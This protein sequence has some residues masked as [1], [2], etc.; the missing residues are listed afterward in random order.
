MARA[1]QMS[2]GA[3]ERKG[4]IKIAAIHAQV[5]LNNNQINRF[6]SD[7]EFSFV[8]ENRTMV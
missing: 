4:K 6:D 1:S 5:E 7:F 8:L 2:C 3:T